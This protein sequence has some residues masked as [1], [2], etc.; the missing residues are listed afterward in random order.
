MAG[1]AHWTIPEYS[2][3]RRTLL[4]RIGHVASQAPNARYGAGDILDAGLA[5]CAENQFVA[6]TFRSL[7]NRGVPIM[8]PQRFLQILGRTTPNE[9][10]EIGGDILEASVTPVVNSGRL[11][12]PTKVAVDEHLIPYLSLIHI[13]EPTRPY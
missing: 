13:S 8:T 6:P 11:S 7:R 9:M 2:R 12:G 10:L 3:T 4:P 1:Q 5:L